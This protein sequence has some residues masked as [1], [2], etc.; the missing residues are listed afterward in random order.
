MGA[1]NVGSISIYFDETVRTNQALTR[2]IPRLSER[3]YA[4]DVKLKRGE[5]VGSFNFGST[6][7]LVF[8]SSEEFQF[9]AAVGDRVVVGE[10]LGVDQPQVPPSPTF[11]APPWP[12]TVV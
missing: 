4:E 6:I 5:M 2:A 1:L 9:T 10:R 3:N 12:K 7:V 8:E 11:F